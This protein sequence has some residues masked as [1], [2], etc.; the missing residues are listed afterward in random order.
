MSSSF[1]VGHAGRSSG[2]PPPARLF[3]ASVARRR[4]EQDAVLLQ[5]RIALL[6]G[7]EDRGRQKINETQQK[8]AEILD[9]R[10]R[11]AHVR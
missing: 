7:E 2:G 4:A 1:H 9:M 8:A 3:H 11:N 5:N 6:R 10:D